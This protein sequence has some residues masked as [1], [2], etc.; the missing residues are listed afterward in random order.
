MTVNNQDSGLGGLE[1]QGA[2]L[3]GCT[4]LSE[5]LKPVVEASSFPRCALLAYL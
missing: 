3:G 5:E 4:W 2:V 1:L